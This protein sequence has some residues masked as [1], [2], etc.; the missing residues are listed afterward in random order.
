[1]EVDGRPNS[2]LRF[3]ETI[4]YRAP[5]MTICSVRRPHAEGAAIFDAV[6]DLPLV[7][8]QLQALL[9]GVRGQTA[10]HILQAGPIRLNV[11]MRTVYSLNG[12]HHMTPKQ[13]ALLQMLMQNHDRV[14][15]R[16]EIMAAVWETTY[17]ADTR[18]LDVHIRWLRECIE[19]D[20]SEP[21]YLQTV[22][23]KGYRLRT[24]I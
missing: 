18:T 9:A 23:G 20:P 12:Q 17:M 13:C 3:C 15:S 24:A 2:R 16:S 7:R 8:E 5:N 21:V 6:L 19:L 22:R 11:A 4:R 14:V 1:M 10:G